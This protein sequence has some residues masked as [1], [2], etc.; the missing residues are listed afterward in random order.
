[1]LAC[2]AVNKDIYILISTFI[3]YVGKYGH[4]FV[5]MV[6]IGCV[7]RNTL[8]IEDMKCER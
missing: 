1:M 7:G 4:D 5:M 3:F 6:Y 2:G 8:R